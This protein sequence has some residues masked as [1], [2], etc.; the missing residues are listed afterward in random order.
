MQLYTGSY[1]LTLFGKDHET[2]FQYMQPHEALFLE[3]AVE[4]KYV[5]KAEERAQGKIAPFVFKVKK[6]TMLGNVSESVLKSF[7]LNIDSPMLTPSFREDLVRVIR[8]HKGHTPLEIFLYDPK[9]RYRIQFK[10]N[11]FEV[12]VSTD[13]LTDLRRIGVDRYEVVRK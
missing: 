9:T 13:L 4:E 8:K 11:K 6:I 5:V 2:F 1:E 7:G 12:A 10:S 3:G